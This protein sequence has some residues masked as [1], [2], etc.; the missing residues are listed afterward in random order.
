MLA[1]VANRYARH[2]RNRR[3]TVEVAYVELEECEDLVKEVQ[4]PARRDQV[5][6]RD[7]LLFGI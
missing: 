2:G 6:K 5:Q 3:K 1:G 7:A 4:V